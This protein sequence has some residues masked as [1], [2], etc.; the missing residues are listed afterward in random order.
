MTLKF[1]IQSIHQEF[2]PDLFI[3]LKLPLYLFLHLEALFSFWN[4]VRKLLAHPAVSHHARCNQEVLWPQESIVYCRIAANELCVL[5][6]S[7][8]LSNLPLVL[9]VNSHTIKFKSASQTLIRLESLSEVN[10][11]FSAQIFEIKLGIV[12]DIKPRQVIEISVF[13]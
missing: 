7:K 6:S 3:F 1:C 4:A 11:R 9:S 10:D 2:G 5:V 13:G 8:S 12:V